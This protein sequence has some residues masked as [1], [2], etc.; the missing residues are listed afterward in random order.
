MQHYRLLAEKIQLA[1]FSFNMIL[2]FVMNT[3]IQP[4]IIFLVLFFP[5]LYVSLIHFSWGT[6][7]FH[8]LNINDELLRIITHNIPALC[9]IWYFLLNE[10]LRSVLGQLKPVKKDIW[11]V[12]A[13][14]FWLFAVGLALSG[15]MS[16][17]LPAE[18]VRGVHISGAASW[19]IIALS[20][21]STGYVE[22]SYFR[23][24]LINHLTLSGFPRK[25]ALIASCILFSLCHFYQGPLGLIFSLMAGL[26]LS[27][28]YIKSRSIHG[29]ALGHGFYNLASFVLAHI[30]SV[31]GV[32][33]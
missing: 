31:S 17:V 27:Y 16:F 21:I 14:F 18:E 9:L 30:Q 7:Q 3:L 6:A 15:V 8:A 26:L 22:E 10:P 28:T 1:V 29:I 5:G 2:Y 19:L 25:K 11:Q 20:C 12:I 23:V 33:M 4:F 24:Y 32:S 13:V